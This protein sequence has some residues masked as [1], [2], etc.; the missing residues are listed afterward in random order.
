MV[1]SLI[2]LTV[3]II[4]N[5]FYVLYILYMLFSYLMIR[6]IYY[7]KANEY[8]GVPIYIYLFMPG[9]GS[10]LLIFI[11][12]P[13]YYFKRSSFLIEDYETYIRFKNQLD[14]EKR[15]N[16]EAS[17]KIISGL[18][19]MNYL[20]PAAKKQMIIEKINKVSGSKIQILKTANLDQDTEVQHYAAVMLNEI[21]NNFNNKIYALKEDYKK[22]ASLKILDQLIL[23]YKKYIDSSL[24]EKNALSIYNDEYIRLLK[25]RKKEAGLK[26]K[27]LID[28]MDAYIQKMDYIKSREVF[29]LGIKRYPRLL[30]LY[31]LK[32]KLDLK[33]NN[34]EAIQKDIEV[35]KTFD[36]SQIKSKHCKSQLEF[37]SHKP[38]ERKL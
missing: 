5:N 8:Q 27:H 21:E 16:Y 1:M 19:L 12:L 26:E 2:F 3:V 11:L 32:L 25:I 18:D 17:I 29:E 28:L 14:S 24:L 36:S 33:L 37:W 15:F 23:A 30:E 13:L 22:N 9:L 4:L 20:S 10:I 34:D 38:I 35:L 7:N 31:L 6:Y